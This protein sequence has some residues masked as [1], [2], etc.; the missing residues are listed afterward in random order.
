M[1]SIFLLMLLLSTLFSNEK[2]INHLLKFIESTKCTYDRNGDKHTGSK[3]VKHIKKKYKYY[4][5]DI[6]TTEDFIRL[7]ATKSMMSGSVYKIHC[8][9][10]TITSKQW[11]LKELTKYRNTSIQKVW[12]RKD[13]YTN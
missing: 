2:E 9:K 10:E 4:Y 1:K 13:A 11:L 8:D 3:A 6:K 7:A 5:D 12:H